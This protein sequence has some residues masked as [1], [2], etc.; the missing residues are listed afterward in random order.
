MGYNLTNDLNEPKSVL[1]S[2]NLIKEIDSF[3][4]R[5]NEGYED[6]LKAYVIISDLEKAIKN[7]KESILDK[8]LAERK[9]YPEKTVE[10]FGKKISIS[11]SGRYDYSNY[12]VWIDRNKEI[13]EIEEAMKNS[14]MIA[15]SGKLMID[16]DSEIIP[17]AIFIPSKESLKLG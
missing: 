15:K 2:L 1:G 17:P 4:Q 16:S 14:Y 5:V 11:Q 6:E 13:K 12:Q 7:A 10:L 3:I 8:A 9:K